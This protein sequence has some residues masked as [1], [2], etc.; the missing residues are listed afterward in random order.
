MMITV[1]VRVV[2][3][4][5]DV[6]YPEKKLEEWLTRR[7]IEVLHLEHWGDINA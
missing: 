3:V 6:L 4:C 7:S 2:M 1:Q 5:M